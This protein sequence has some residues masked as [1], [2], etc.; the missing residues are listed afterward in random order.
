MRA[1]RTAAGMSGCHAA[2]R[3]VQGIA[4]NGAAIIAGHR[5]DLKGLIEHGGVDL[6]LHGCPTRS[7]RHLDAVGVPADR[8]GIQI[9]AAELCLE[10]IG[11]A[12]CRLSVAADVDGR[13]CKH[14][15]HI[16]VLLELRIGA[17]LLRHTIAPF[18]EHIAFL[19]NSGN[20][21]GLFCAGDV[22]G[23]HR[24]AAGASACLLYTSP[25]PRDRSVSRMPSSA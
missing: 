5:V 1:G 17:G 21:D 2:D 25:S 22:I 13:L 11:I 20:T 3:H 4:G 6:H 8:V 9:L 14:S 10:G 19:R 15:R 7:L 16:H 23:Q 12:Q 18:D 24:L